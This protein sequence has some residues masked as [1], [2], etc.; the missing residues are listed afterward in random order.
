MGETEQ[1]YTGVA[2]LW[3]IALGA[4]PSAAALG[5]A[6]AAVAAWQHYQPVPFHN[7]SEREI[8]GAQIERADTLPGDVEVLVVGDSSGLMGVDPSALGAGLGGARVESLATLGYVGPRGYAALIERILRRGGH[9]ARVILTLQE[10]SLSRRQHWERYA[11]LVDTGIVGPAPPSQLFAGVRARLLSIADLVLFL[12]MPGQF[13][14]FYGNTAGIGKYMREHHGSAI[15]PNGPLP[16]VAPPDAGPQLAEINDLFRTALP[17]LGRAVAA[18]GTARVRLV[19]MPQVDW[20]LTDAARASRAAAC[21]EVER[22]LR[23]DS[24]RRLALPEGLPGPMFASSTHLSP[25]GRQYYTKVLAEVLAADR[26]RWPW[27]RAA[28]RVP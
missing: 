22:A 1:T 13:G 18:I 5:L 11:R 10:T 4:L 26:M 14:D 27:P 19:L 12:P 24:G 23:L 2:A 17:R 28:P 25:A 21:D 7:P 6:L 8:I 15:D 16:A 20:S 9:P 3:R